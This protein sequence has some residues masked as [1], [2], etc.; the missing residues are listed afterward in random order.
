MIIMMISS[1]QF[2][3]SNASH[4]GIFRQESTG[5]IMLKMIQTHN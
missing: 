3:A 1:L 5:L 2:A 4:S